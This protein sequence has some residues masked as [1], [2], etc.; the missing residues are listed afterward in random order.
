MA[1]YRLDPERSRFSVHTVATGLLSFMGHSPTFAVRDF[2]GVV[3]FEDDLIAN[4]RLELTVGA[5]GLAVTADVKAT[6]RREIQDRM[7]AEVLETPA[8]PDIRFRAAAAATDRLAQG[9]YRVFLEGTLS[10][11][12]VAR[13]HR[14]DAELEVFADSLRL[15][16]KT[17]LRMSDYG[18]RPVTALG[19]TI[20]LKDDVKLAFDLVAL[21]EAS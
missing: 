9:R 21:P 2:T 20:R 11:H 19:G 3:D 6:D 5:G 7:R 15:R 12:G 18:I 1:R 14:L 4:L 13:A 10:L 17:G 16:G 8:F